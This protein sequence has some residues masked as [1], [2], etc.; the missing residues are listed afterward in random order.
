MSSECWKCREA[1]KY[2][3]EKK[4]RALEEARQRSIDEK[5]TMAIF[6]EGCLWRVE[7]AE[8]AIA[9]G[10]TDYELVSVN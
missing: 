2:R 4:Q 8:Q 5:S 3:L 1:A 10:R 9:N 6:K 7:P